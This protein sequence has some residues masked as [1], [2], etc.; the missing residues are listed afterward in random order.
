VH[1]R[2]L[3]PV[4]RESSQGGSAA[5]KPL[6]DRAPLRVLEFDAVW[7]IRVA[8]QAKVTPFASS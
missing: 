5:W 1:W 3:D 6:L 2:G 7:E 4:R 8:V